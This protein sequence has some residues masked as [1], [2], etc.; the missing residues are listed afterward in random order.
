MPGIKNLLASW[1]ETN[2]K[3]KRS[4]FVERFWH[5][6]VITSMSEQEFTE[7]YN[8]LGKEKKYVPSQEKAKV[9]YALAQE[10]I[11]TLPSETSSIKMLVTEAVRVLKEVD[12]TLGLIFITDAGNSQDFARIFGCKRNGWSGKYI[13]PK[14]NCRNRRCSQISQREGIGCIRRN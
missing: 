12:A 10:S 8:T 2:R 6:D 13:S 11:P 14:V 1:N 9:I 5:Y 7:E 4:D 3:D